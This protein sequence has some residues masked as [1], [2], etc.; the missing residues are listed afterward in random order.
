MRNKILPVVLLAALLALFPVPASAEPDEETLEADLAEAI[1]AVNDAQEQVE[2]AEDR[3]ADLEGQIEETQA[4]FDELKADLNEYALYLHTEGD[5]QQTNAILSSTDSRSLID[6]MTYTGFLGN[7]RAALLAE[8]GEVLDELE[9]EQA[10][11]ADQVADAAEALKDAEKAQEDLEEELEELR[12]EEA[13]GPGSDGGAPAAESGPG[14][15]GGCT[16]D[17]PTTSGCLTPATLHVYN[18]TKEAG[19]DHYVSC[20]RSG[21]SG[22]HPLGRA[23]DWAANAS[24]FQDVDAS[25]DDKTYGDQLAAWYVNNADALGVEYVI[26]YRQFWSPGSEWRSYSGVNG[27]PA[28]DHTNH[29]HVSVR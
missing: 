26:W 10:A 23:C 18:E 27:T 22:E 17:D 19:F 24:G 8:A 5:L 4:R 11:H 16:E 12:A 29:V 7:E 13:A 1:A 9:A 28:G 25:G 15:G 20:Y 14:S 21:G 2:A 3:A 6:A